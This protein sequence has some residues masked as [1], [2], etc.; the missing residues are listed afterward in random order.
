MVTKK[1]PEEGKIVF[2][3]SEAC[4]VLDLS[5]NTLKKLV[6]N[7]DIRVKRV[8]RRYLFPKEAIDYYLNREAF[9]AKIFLKGLR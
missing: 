6:R 9:E 2:S 3:A 5:W 4:Y 1:K 8:G 7:G